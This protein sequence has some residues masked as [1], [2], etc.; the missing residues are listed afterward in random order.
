M[1]IDKALQ[2]LIQSKEF[3]ELAKEKNAD[4]GKLRMFRTRYQRG[5][6]S[7]GAAVSLLEKFGYGIEIKPSTT[8]K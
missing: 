8:K 1:E 4:G 5:E 6:V 2:N 3:K 7:T